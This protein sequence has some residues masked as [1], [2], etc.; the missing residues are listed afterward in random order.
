[1]L[2]LDNISIRLA[3]R[4]LLDHSSVALPENGKIGFVGRNG[5]GKSTLFRALMG[6]LTLETGTIIMPAGLRIGQVA[7]EVPG[8]NDRLIDIVLAADKERAALLAEAETVRDPMRLAEIHMHLADKNAYA[9]PARA[10]AILHGLGFNAEAQQQSAAQ[11]SGGWRMRVALAAMLFAEPDLLLLD[12]PTNYLDIEGVLWLTDYIKRYPHLALIISHD[13]DLLNRSVD[14]ILHL[15]RQKLHFW[16][17]NY[18]SFARQRVEKMALQQKQAAGQEAKRRHM[19]AFVTRFRAKATKAKQAQS[20]LKMLEKM[21]FVTIWRDEQVEPFRFP[22]AVKAVASPI[23][24]LTNISLGY[25]P[26]KPVLQNLN[27]RI[28]KQDRIALLG[29]NGNGKST[30]ARFLAGRLKPQTGT[31]VFAPDLKIA[32]FAQH[33][34]DDLYP[35]E[36]AIEHFRRL[37]PQEP[38]AKLRARIARTGL[39]T[40]KMQTK[41]KNLSG[42]EKA[43]LLMGLAVYDA[44]HLLILDEPTNHLDIDSREELIEALNNFDGAIIVISHDRYLIEAGI[45]RLWQA[46]EGGITPYDGDMAHYAA[47]ILAESRRKNKD[48]KLPAGQIAPQTASAQIRAIKRE[49]T[50]LLR[51][52]INRIEDLL[53]RQQQALQHLNDELARPEFYQQPNNRLAEKTALHAALTQK[54][55]QQEAEWLSLQE[56]LDKAEQNQPAASGAAARRLQQ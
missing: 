31:A 2:I 46:A 20:R 17:G 5:A 55:Q 18:D 34:M 26:D 28:D 24:H 8:S 13:R 37:L 53:H 12:E 19:E 23:I 50:A 21:Q 25:Q 47:N 3:G 14:A 36:T 27:L 38:E 51:K 1:M 42:G 44:P 48:K 41:A 30:F 10:G 35:E 22:H 49:Q 7:Q 52:K 29:A 45:D 40:E 39:S 15:D 16:Q 32:F 43:R 11:F 9:A 56:E 54:L 6:D 4:L 33:Q